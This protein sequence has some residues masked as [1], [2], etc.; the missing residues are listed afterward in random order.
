MNFRGLIMCQCELM[1]RTDGCFGLL[2]T[3]NLTRSDFFDPSGF[4]GTPQ[5]SYETNHFLISQEEFSS[6]TFHGRM[7]NLVA[8]PF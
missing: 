1:W 6:L 8:V 4:Y 3:Y 7:D 5:E 2:G